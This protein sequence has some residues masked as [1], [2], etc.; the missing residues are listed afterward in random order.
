MLTIKPKHFRIM[1]EI[2]LKTRDWERLLTYEQQQKYKY[3]IKQGWFSDYHGSSWRHDT[4]YGAY[5]WKHPKYIN[6]VRTFSDLVGHKPLWSDITDDNLRDLTEKIQELYAPNSSRTICATIKAVIRENDEKG[7]RSSK[8]DSILRVKRVPVQAVYLDDN[9]IQSLIDYIPHGSVERYVKRMFILECL[10]GARLSDCHNITPENIDDTGKYIVYVAQKTKAEVRVPLHKKLRSFL[11]CG[12]AD[13]PVGGV[14]DVYFN[15]VLR[16]IC[17]NCGIDTRV[18]VFKCGKYESGPKFKFV[19]SHT[20]RRSFATN[21][22]K[23][24]L[25]VEQ[26]AIMMGHANGGKPN[27]EMTQ[28]YIVGKTNIDTRTLRVFGI[29]DDDYN[30]VGDEC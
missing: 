4:F 20:G 21:L 16:E 8:F 11:V 14:V 1:K 3:A 23:N 2:H 6:V 9:E 25:P 30:S 7:I 13:E 28:R 5:I 12:T 27:I 22:S 29:Y 26:I 17:S 10:C 24:G 18:K 19:S 15:K